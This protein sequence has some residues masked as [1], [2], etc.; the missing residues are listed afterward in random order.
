[1]PDCGTSCPGLYDTVLLP[2]V[3]AYSWTAGILAHYIGEVNLGTKPIAE[4][5]VN[6]MY[7]TQL[8]EEVKASGLLFHTSPRGTTHTAIYLCIFPH[9][10]AVVK[11]MIGEESNENVFNAWA[12]GKAFGYSENA[13]ADYIGKLFPFN[14]LEERI[15]K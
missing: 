3:D 15:A 4:I 8:L 12:W 13:I 2:P 5:P 10:L 1:M 11:H 9:L 14:S 7:A 6:N